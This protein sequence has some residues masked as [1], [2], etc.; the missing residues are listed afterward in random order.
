MH[1][2]A[3]DILRCPFCGSSL[4][5]VDGPGQRATSQ[6]VSAGT[7][8]CGCEAYPIVDGIPCMMSSDECHAA[9]EAIGLDDLDKARLI[10]LGLGQD[11]A[12]S[13][14]FSSLASNSPAM[15]FRGALEVLGSG[16]EADYFLFR[17]SD[18]YFV[19]SEYLLRAIALSGTLPAGR[20]IDLCGGAGHLTRSMLGCGVFSEV[21]LTDL[22]FWKLW[23]ARRFIAPL[24][25]AVACDSGA[26][27]PFTR[28]SFSLALCSG[29]FEYV[30]SR[31]TFGEEIQRLVGQRGL[32][33]LTHL[34]N[35]H[36]GTFNP[37][38]ALS[39]GGYR[40][41]FSHWPTSMCSEV[42]AFEAAM[43]REPID[44]GDGQS[45]KVL[46]DEPGLILACA[47]EA[48]RLARYSAPPPRGAS[49]LQINPLY[50]PVEVASSKV[51][52]LSFPSDEY[53][54]EFGAVRRYLPDRI[55][56]KSLEKEAAFEQRILLDLP[57]NYL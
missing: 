6:V 23:L 54:E 25:T 20:A 21:W 22:S 13:S 49:S 47:Y 50:R 11:A 34:K 15:T 51:Y 32:L 24:A 10:L 5:L 18:P 43:A 27:L 4:E 48:S 9:N 45:E 41:I 19:T 40:G 16:Q 17:F 2:S 3:L 29:A 30:W 44:L 46:D 12:R 7:L 37:G 57:E 56:L 31:R 1:L 38:N 33:L 39:P 35:L 36:C 42:S 8:C 53:V 14:A 28:D 26:G 55:D 52:E